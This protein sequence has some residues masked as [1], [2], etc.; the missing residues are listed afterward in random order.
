[1]PTARGCAAVVGVTPGTR[2]DEAGILV[3]DVMIEFDGHPVG[4]P[5]D[6]LELLAATASV[7]AYAQG[8]RGEDSRDKRDRRE[9]PE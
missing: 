3:G 2:R 5:E 4:S 9:R 7:G 1:V 6:L 8:S